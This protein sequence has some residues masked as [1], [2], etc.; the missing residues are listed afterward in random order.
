MIFSYFLFCQWEHKNKKLFS[1][2]SIF[3]RFKSVKCYSLKNIYGICRRKLQIKLLALFW[4][5]AHNKHFTWV[6]CSVFYIFNIH[7]RNTPTDIWVKVFKNRPSKICGREPLKN[8]NWC[9]LLRQSISLQMSF[10]LLFC[11]DPFS[12]AEK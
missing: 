4:S 2:Y 10:Y 8:L 11:M 1:K 3:Y 6:V 12:L 9:G 5:A 7:K